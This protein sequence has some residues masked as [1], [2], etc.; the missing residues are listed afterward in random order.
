MSVRIEMDATAPGVHTVRLAGELDLSGY[1]VVSEALKRLEREE[2][3]P[4]RVIVD[5]RDLSFMDS[6]GARVLAEAHRRSQRGGHRLSVVPGTGQ[7][8][9]LIEMLR[10]DG[11]L[12][13]I[14][15]PAAA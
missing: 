13:M 8:S 5:L 14:P 9:R 7:P 11:H 10:L 15:D 12:E 3:A 1:D 4:E 6:T 2:P